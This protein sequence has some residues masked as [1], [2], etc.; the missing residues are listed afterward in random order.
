M[1]AIVSRGPDVGLAYLVIG[2]PGWGDGRLGSFPSQGK[3]GKR[4]TGGEIL[5]VYA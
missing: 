5:S 4:E 3:R 1:S 2:A